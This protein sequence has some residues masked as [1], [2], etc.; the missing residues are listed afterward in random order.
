TRSILVVGPAERHEEI[1]KILAA[2]DSEDSSRGQRVIVY[3][4]G[5]INGYI[6]QQMVSQLMV[7]ERI[8]VT[9][10]YE[11]GGNQLVVVAHDRQHAVIRDALEQMQPPETD[12]EVFALQQLDP[13]IAED[14]VIG[15]FASFL[16]G[17]SAPVVEVDQDNNRLYVRATPKQ[18]AKIRDLLTKMGERQLDPA[19]PGSSRKKTRFVP[20]SGSEQEAIES[21]RAIWPKLRNNDLRVLDREQLRKSLPREPATPWLPERKPPAKPAPDSSSG[22]QDTG[23]AAGRVGFCLWQSLLGMHPGSLF[24]QLTT[25][26]GSGQQATGKRTAGE[27]AGNRQADTEVGDTGG[28]NPEPVGQNR[29]SGPPQPGS[30]DRAATPPPV[31]I[32]PGPQGVTIMSEDTEALDQLEQLLSVVSQ[33]QSRGSRRM[34]VY[35]LKSSSASRLADTL[36]KLYRSVPNSGR[37]RSLRGKTSF[38]ADERLNA[39]VV[40]ASRSD[41]QEIEELL[42]ILDVEQTPDMQA[43][44]RPVVIPLK[45]AR[46]VTVEKQLRLLYKTQLTAGG[47]QPAMEIPSGANAR[48]AALIE[49]INA[50]RQGPLMTLGTDEDTNSILVVAPPSLIEEVRK[51]VEEL[52]Q[53]AHEHPRRAV[54]IVPLKKTNAAEMDRALQRVLRSGRRR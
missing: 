15:L 3:P 42:K 20:L 48:A 29:A 28:R 31:Y 32:V 45:R 11:P 41:R 54:R 27:A 1:K 24:C 37:G 5:R 23:P 30:V 4:L 35:P 13:L 36:N 18:L 2:A 34:F 51:F 50:I 46:A 44:H 40:Y 17:G 9:L 19:D 49:Q 21:I 53:A 47:K 25:V 14:A 10:S 26:S 39:L 12:F 38:V 33:P 7:K 16:E 8:P 6:A 52:D 43:T 22:Q